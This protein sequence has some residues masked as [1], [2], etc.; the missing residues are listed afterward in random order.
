MVKI[1]EITQKF[2]DKGLSE[3]SISNYLKNLKRL[4]NN[5]DLNDL[6]FLENT[7]DILKKLEKY[8][9]NTKRSYLIAIVST[10]KVLEPKSKLFKFYYDQM[11]Q[12]AQTIK[13]DDT[14]ELSN[15]QKKNWL[16]WKE[17]KE[18][19]EKLKDKVFSFSKRGKLQRKQYED[20]LNLV[21]TAL[22]ICQEPRRN[23]DYQILY[24]TKN[25]KSFFTDTHN[26]ITA[27]YFIF[28]RYK[29]DKKYGT[30]KILINDEL[31][32]ILDLYYKHS[33]QPKVKPEIFLV[34]YDKKPL[35]KINSITRILNS[36]F[37]KNIGSS[38]L[39]HIYLTH[40]YGDKL[41]E[42]KESANNMAHSLKTQKEYIKDP[43]DTEELKNNK[44]YKKLKVNFD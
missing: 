21:V 4:N 20:L 6:K 19:F 10:L 30:Q 29:T 14:S 26:Y 18:I 1:Q 42:Q 23:L 2:K 5:N 7:E 17:I 9:P 22:Y 28:N 32:P 41:K 40:K 27:N 24:K 35:D 37:G 3:S 36:V 11:I 8:K 43:T 34:D 13:K 39:R 16:D 25:Y 38:L 44:L 15:S 31:K 12:I 33:G